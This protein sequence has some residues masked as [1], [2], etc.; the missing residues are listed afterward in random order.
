MSVRRQVV[1]QPVP[2]QRSRSLKDVL[3]IGWAASVG[4][5]TDTEGGSETEGPSDDDDDSL[6]RVVADSARPVHTEL[7]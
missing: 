3:G 6:L 2:K 5:N 7:H 1:A 4:V